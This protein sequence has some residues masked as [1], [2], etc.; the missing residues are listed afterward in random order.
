MNI[1]NRQK[2]IHRLNVR[3]L[4]AVLSL[5]ATAAQAAVLIVDGQNPA[6]KDD[7]PGTE[8]A[9]FKTIQAA[10]NKATKPDDTVRVRGGVYHESVRVVG[11]GYG[12]GNV[13]YHSAANWLTLEAC[14][15]ERVVLDGSAEVAAG[16]WRLVEGCTNTYVAA[17]TGQV[18]GD[19]QAVFVDDG[20]IGPALVKNPKGE[21]ERPKIAAVPADNVA[22]PCFFHDVKNKLLYVNLCGKA[23]GRE[24]RVEPIVY[25]TAIRL[26]PNRL[27][28]IRKLEM[29]RFNY[30]GVEIGE[31]H[32]ALISDCYMHHCGQGIAA[33]GVSGGRILHNVMSD[34]FYSGI[35]MTGGRAVVV[36]NNVIRRFNLNPYR[37]GNIYVSSIGMVGGQVLGNVIRNNVITDL[38]TGSASGGGPW[39]DC[40]GAGLILYG[41]SVFRMGSGFY[42]EAGS[43]GCTLRWNAVYD[44]VEGIALRANS[45]HMV[46]ENYVLRNRRMAMCAGSLSDGDPQSLFSLNGDTFIYNWLIENRGPVTPTPSPARE[47]ACVFD[48]NT[49]KA[50]DTNSTLFMFDGAQFKNLD[51]LRTSLG[52]EIHGKVVKEF[53]ATRTCGLVSFRLADARKPWE[54]IPM[55]G[56]PDMSRWDLQD[57]TR[58]YFWR[59]GTFQ[60]EKW[61]MKRTAVRRQGGWPSSGWPF[62]WPDTG[63]FVA[64]CNDGKATGKA[65]DETCYLEMGSIEDDQPS[66][67]EGFGC[68]S[69]ALPTV[70]DAVVDISMFV[71]G[72]DLK[73]AA[74]GG[75]FYAFAEFRD[76]TGQNAT[77][78]FIAG[79]PDTGQAATMKLA[80]GTY[81][82][83]EV[84]QSVTAPKGARWVQLAFGTRNCTGRAQVDTVTIQTRPGQEQ[85]LTTPDPLGNFPPVMTKV[86]ALPVPINAAAFAWQPVDLAALLNRPLTDDA[87]DDGRGGWFD[88]GP[89]ADLRNL[90]PGTSDFAG[91]PFRIEKDKACFVTKSR[92]RKSDNLPDSGKV[93]LKAKADLMACLHSGG[94]T[95]E[96]DVKQATYILHYA[97]GTRASMPVVTGKN[98]F[99]WIAPPE[100]AND[101]AYDPALGFVQHAGSVNTTKFPSVHLWLVLWANPH[102]DKE[103]VAF[104]VKG[105]NQGIVGLLGVTLGHKR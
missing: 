96:P 97:D 32:D 21:A 59:R 31:A 22:V 50:L 80:T 58:T 47:L 40:G 4:A 95:A 18:G 54:P 3:D 6:A 100:I 103:I 81:A 14:G 39:P 17:Y 62:T 63:A 75:G 92:F 67:A 49:Y 72:Q 38:M 20:M 30:T 46:I 27:V 33:W 13:N 8:A 57:S 48:H 79:A 102:P 2:T 93:E 56:N 66:T 64:Q 73:A 55:F 28:R 15:D 61:E 16:Q 74:P 36:D 77:R 91:V 76:E 104:E 41:N 5:L 52:V 7:N 9:P 101:V 34:L 70:D 99:D 88:L 85:P 23:P 83:T 12:A 35:S 90:S 98:I 45:A 19:I 82:Y 43:F 89:Q 71:R 65:H 51:S 69:T 87:P 84:K 78:Q 24:A 29:R 10:F 1:M 11:S 86:V 25:E 53:D 60:G 68:W 105:E 26:G 42:I 44:N 37:I 94:W